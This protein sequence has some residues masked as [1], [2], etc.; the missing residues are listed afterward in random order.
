MSRCRL[1]VDVGGTFTDFV[2]FDEESHEMWVHKSPTIPQDQTQGISTGAAA[3][4]EQQDAAPEDLVYVALGSTIAIN[5]MLQGQTAPVG[6]ITTQGFRDL[7]ELRRQRRNALFDLFFQLPIPLAPRHLRLGVPERVNAE[8]EVLVSLDEDK[9]REALARLGQAGV[10]SVAVCFLFSFLNP[11]H[12]LRVEE[13]AREVI[14]GRSIWLSHRVLP[15]FREFERLSTT[16]CNAALGPT[17]EAYLGNI[18]SRMEKLGCRRTPYI[19]QS[20]GGVMTLR[21][22]QERPANT[23]FSGPSAGVVG[24]LHAARLAG[25]E[26]VITFDMGGTSTDVCLVK[27]GAISMVHEKEI[28][29]TPV[30]TPMVDVNSVGAGGGSIAWIDTGGRLKVGPQSAGARPGPA[31]YGQGGERPTV[32]DANLVLGR[33][34]PHGLLAGRMPLYPDLAMEAIQ[35]YVAQPLGLEPL[36]AAAGIVRIVNTNMV[37]AIRAVSVQRGH[38]PRDF[39]LAAFGGAG[40][41]HASGV[42]RQ[43][44]ISLMVVPPAPGI[45]CAQ[46]L[47]VTDMRTDYVRT[48]VSPLLD[49][50]LNEVNNLLSGLEERARAWLAAEAEGAKERSVEFSADLRY[51][52]QNYELPVPAAAAPWRAGTFQELAERFHEE[53][54]RAY[55]YRADQATV[56]LVNLRAT[57]LA[58]IPKP[59]PRSQTGASPGGPA[60]FEHRGVWWE[61]GFASTPVYR[62]ADLPAGS[63]LRG[64]AIVEQMDST[65]LVAPEE[66]GEVDGYGNLI[67]SL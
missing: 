18:K 36:E 62:R 4:L 61:E 23:L 13:L 20:N 14:P 60:P 5:A 45:L 65:T 42:A 37:L 2:L 26:N 63:T 30:R 28:G 54:R 43:L 67:L 59:R 34:N 48:F 31:A 50:D 41:L 47:L 35:R 33:L 44:G 11:S 32:T 27:Q 53:H 55:G 64:P 17:M 12:E 66:Q 19:M 58:V 3:L 16:A 56:Q 21:G 9:V 39:T 52:G 7:L 10:K 15:E 46:G 8:G 6:I 29:G 51:V 57:A 25:A 24:G 38:D 1:G 40:P 22:A 49:A